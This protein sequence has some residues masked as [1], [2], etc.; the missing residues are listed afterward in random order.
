[1][2]KIIAIF[3][4]PDRG[5]PMVSHPAIKAIKGLGLEG[6]RY[7]LQKGSWMAKGETVHKKKRNVT[8]MSSAAMQIANNLRSF[9]TS[10]TMRETRR[11]VF[12]DGLDVN[13]LIGKEFRIG[14]VLCRGIEYAEPCNRPSTLCKKEGFQ[15]AFHGNGGVNCEILENGIITIGDEIQIQV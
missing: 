1:M 10:F 9:T 8:L 5:K 4:A 15:G 3:T 11:N 6:D 14:S 7:A 13:V 2:A 12:V